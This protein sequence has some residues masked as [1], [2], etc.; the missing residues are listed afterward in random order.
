VRDPPRLGL[1]LDDPGHRLQKRAVVRDGDEPATEPLDKSF[2]ERQARVVEVV[3]RLV[4]QQYV[5][6][7]DEDLLELGSCR[8]ATRTPAPLGLLREVAN[9]QIRRLAHDPPSIRRLDPGQDPQ[10]RRLTDAVGPDD[11]DP[12]L[13]ADD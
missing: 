13:R 7:V 10:Q 5:G 1:E 4:E 9:R 2:E 8:L 6:I 11:A 12:A 3:G